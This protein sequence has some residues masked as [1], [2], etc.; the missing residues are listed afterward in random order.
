VTSPTL[1]WQL[2]KLLAKYP[3]AT[4]NQFEPLGRDS[5]REGARLAFGEYVDTVYDFTKAKVVLSLDANFLEE[6]VGHVRYARDFAASRDVDVHLGNISRLYVAE[7]APTLT[8]AS[9]DHKLN[10]RYH[11][12]ETLARL[13]A[14]QLGIAGVAPAEEARA[15]VAANWLGAVVNDL[16]AAAGGA[17]VL[18]G[19]QQPAIVHAIAHAI[20]T[21]LGSDRSGLVQYVEPVEASP[22][23]QLASVRS[24][25][26]AMNAG[27]VACLVMLGGNPVYDTP[28]D[29]NFAEA[30]NNVAVRVHYTADANETT[31]LSH[32]AIPATHYLESWG[33]VR[34]HDGT[35]SIVQPLILPMYAGKTVHEVMS[36]L[37]GEEKHQ[38]A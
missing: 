1:V 33:D 9:A 6:G 22:V 23:N 24:L 15:T 17:V 3:K 18:A 20:N 29:L 14:E 2:Q 28:A 35:I 4:W 27:Q 30:L 36:V 37:L 11:D 25:V 26:E 8:G 38:S 32:W 13:V 21:H 34:G 12:V 7:S 16:K 31:R 5:I 19:E 10:L